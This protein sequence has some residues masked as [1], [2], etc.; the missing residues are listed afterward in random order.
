MAK[1][2]KFNII[3]TPSGWMVSVPGSMTASGNRERHFH[4]TKGKAE[5]H[6]QDLRARYRQHGEA[7]AAIRPALA[8]DATQA[9]SILAG[10]EITLASV[11]RFY[12]DFMAQRN[13]CPTLGEAW[14]AGLKHRAKKRPSTLA[15]Y[16]QW[17]KALPTWFMDTNLRQM[18]GEDV[19]R[20]L[21]EVTTGPTRWRGGL[22][23][24]RAIIGDVM[25]SRKLLHNPAKAATPPPMDETQGEVVIY[26]PAELTAL[27]AACVD[28][29][30][31]EARACGSCAVPFAFMAFAG[32]RPE[33]ITKLDWKHVSLEL[34]NIRIGADVA[35]KNYL[36]NVTITP[37]LAAWIESVPESE[38]TGKIIGFSNW[39]KKA[40][41]VRK[42]AGICGTEKQ[43]GLRHS[44]GSYTLAVTGDLDALKQ[45]MGHAH[46]AIFFAHY[47]HAM[48]KREALPYFQILPPGVESIPT[49]AVA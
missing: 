39:I 26:T 18:T 5:V 48:T 32:I 27:F 35:K 38:R 10:H 28:Y 34:K 45:D 2:P 36:R 8:E 20:A 25:K 1:H 31:G 4:K 19:T 46:M 16:K 6:A 7:A 9:A 44:F 17:Q 41:R 37:T 47:H 24:V 22:R 23:Y 43:D 21:D 11:A 29:T 42:E 3:K 12:V 33:E 49:I 30:S 13:A 40:G 14:E 15:D